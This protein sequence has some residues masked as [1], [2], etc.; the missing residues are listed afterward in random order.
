MKERILNI[1]WQK[2][3]LIFLK[4][5][6]LFL[7]FVVSCLVMANAELA[8]K[9][10]IFSYPRQKYMLDNPFPWPAIESG[11]YESCILFLFQNFRYR[12]KFIQICKV[13]QVLQIFW[14][15]FVSLFAVV[16][17]VVCLFVWLV[18]CLLVCFV[19]LFFTIYY[20]E[21]LNLIKKKKKKR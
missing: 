5:C 12:L 3:N 19:C 21:K 13:I 11:T 16:V 10:R 20:L 6:N 9:P 2:H 8:E 4:I 15:C 14:S 17:V 7:I 1:L 18:G